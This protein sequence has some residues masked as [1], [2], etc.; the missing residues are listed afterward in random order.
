[1]LLF[2]NSKKHQKT[3]KNTKKGIFGQKTE[4]N[5][6]KMVKNGSKMTIFGLI[7]YTASPPFCQFE[8]WLF[9]LQITS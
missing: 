6:I 8:K 3:P 4:F 9:L 7:L 2:Y 5:R 1:M